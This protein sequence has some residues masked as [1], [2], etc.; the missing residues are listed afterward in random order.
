MFL[1]NIKYTLLINKFTH[2][3][4]YNRKHIHWC[5]HTHTWYSQWFWAGLLM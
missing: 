2:T 3:N 1:Q 5:I 4:L